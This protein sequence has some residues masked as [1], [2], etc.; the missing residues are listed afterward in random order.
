MALFA[1][2]ISLAITSPHTVREIREEAKVRK[3]A[4]KT[5]N[6]LT[7]GIITAG[8]VLALVILAV[9]SAN[10]PIDQ[11]E[12]V[13]T[14]QSR[15]LQTTTAHGAPKG[16]ARPVNSIGSDWIRPHPHSLCKGGAHG[17]ANNSESADI[18]GLRDLYER[19]QKV[20]LGTVVGL[21]SYY[22]EEGR[23]FTRVTLQ[24]EDTI[25][26]EKRFRL[27]FRVPGGEIKADELRVE[28]SHMP[29]FKLGYRGLVFL[30]PNKR[31]W[32][33]VVEGHQGF[34][35]FFSQGPQ[36]SVVRDGLGR[37]LT[38]ISSADR[39]LVR[40]SKLLNGGELLARVRRFK[41]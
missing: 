7:A 30:S 31:L 24:I 5:D 17:H 36:S 35:R 39:M 1:F 38:G 13:A 28:V 26:G 14:Q 37:L 9:K 6:K 2:G 25:K 21:K 11:E 33:P 15:S 32:T 27:H 16:S 19:A 18:L 8:L 4:M 41:E 12:K 20:V 40:G 22:G 23:I 29:R 3:N 34:L 10:V